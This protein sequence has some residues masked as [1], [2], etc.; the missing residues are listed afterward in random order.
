MLYVDRV[1]G[2]FWKRLASIIAV[3]SGHVEHL[4]ILFTRHRVE[5]YRRIISTHCMSPQK[6]TVPAGSLQLMQACSVS[7]IIL[8]KEICTTLGTLYLDTMTRKVIKMMNATVCIQ[9]LLR[10]A[11]NFVIDISNGVNGCTQQS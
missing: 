8:H 11:S 4:N 10:R 5:L 3:K 7:R 9:V 6:Q 2:Q 1:F